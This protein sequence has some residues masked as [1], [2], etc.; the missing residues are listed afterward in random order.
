MQAAPRVS[1]EG[2]TYTSDTLWSHGGNAFIFPFCPPVKDTEISIRDTSTEVRLWIWLVPII[3]IIPS[4]AATH[5]NTSIF[6]GAPRKR[7]RDLISNQLWKLRGP[8][9]SLETSTKHLR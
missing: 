8:M 9:A 7:A 6:S 5:G 2:S 4:R 1:E 3:V